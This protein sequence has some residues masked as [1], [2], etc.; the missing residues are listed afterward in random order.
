MKRLFF[1]CSTGGHLSEMMKLQPL[2]NRYQSI[3]ITEKNP[4]GKQN[5]D[6][7]KT[8][9]LL[10]GTRKHL[11][12]YVFKFGI[13]CLIS[14]YYFIYYR[15]DCIITTGAH[16][17]VPMVYIAKLFRKKIVFIESIARVKSMSL[18]GRLIQ[19]KCDLVI[20]QWPTMIDVYKQ[21]VYG[22]QIL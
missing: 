19:K 3:L 22:G 16:T 4:S 10:Y 15:P 20:V 7:I 9:Y 6:I 5:Q 12:S 8:H 11:F 2:F 18:A 1:I 17:A 21:S 14:L 13:N